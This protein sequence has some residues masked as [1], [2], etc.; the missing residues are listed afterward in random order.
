MD[1]YDQSH[2]PFAISY[3]TP[4]EQIQ[5][6]STFLQRMPLWNV[7]GDPSGEY[8]PKFCPSSN[9]SSWTMYYGWELEDEELRKQ[10]WVITDLY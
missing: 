10:L 5:Q 4:E 2:K 7:L 9:D 3:L 8:E 1:V 6:A